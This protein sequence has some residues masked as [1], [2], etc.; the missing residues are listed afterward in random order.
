MTQVDGDDPA[1]AAAAAGGGG[2]GGAGL[3]CDE[4]AVTTPLTVPDDCLH[5]RHWYA[6]LCSSLITFFAG[7]LLVLSWRIVA[8]TFCQR[9]TPAARHRTATDPE[10]VDQPLSGGSAQVGWMTSAQDWAGG[11]ISG[12][13]TTG[14]ILVSGHL[15]SPQLNS[16][17]PLPITARC[18]VQLGANGQFTSPDATQLVRPVVS[19]Q[20]V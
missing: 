20:A 7:L 10:T 11:M 15:T 17:A 2:G 5:N 9:R 18:P 13:T 12:Q 8:W 3:A 6:F 16:T 1:V 19:C 14:R 4:A